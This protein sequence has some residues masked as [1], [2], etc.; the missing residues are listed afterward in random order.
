MQAVATQ[1]KH[2]EIA[3]LEE[4]LA[5]PVVALVD[6][7]GIPARQMMEM[8]K[9]LRVSGVRVRMS[10]NRLLRRA[11]DSVAAKRP[12][13]EKL[14]DA[15]RKE[16]LALLTSEG[17]PFTI[18]R[19]LSEAQTQAPAKGGETA[20][21]DIVI[22]KGPT[23]FP[24]GPIVGEFQ[25]AGFPAAIQKGQIVIRKRHVAVAEGET[26]SAPVAGALAKL[27]IFPITMGMEL[28]GAY[29]GENFYLP[30]VLDIDYDEFRGQLQSA[31]A[32][33][34]N[35]AMHARWFSDTTTVPLLS[36]A[37]RDALAVA[38]AAAWPSEATIAALLAEAHQQMLGVA[39]HA[40]DG[41]DDELKA[42]QGAAAPVAAAPSTKAKAA[43]ESED[44][45]EEEEEASEEDAVSG[46]GALFE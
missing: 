18:F 16:Q 20:S 2:D 23:P 13:L 42:M 17:S 45:D 43:S 5:A 26:I 3:Q 33:A 7:S 11:I 9:S 46:L 14:A 37:R 31:T 38:H 8:R 35:L 6:V 28:L 15:F 30:E 12:G 25:Q 4:Y 32:G 34:F 21:A 1:W 27:E 22:E 40:G 36:K 44:D 10:R 41:A 39:G 24:A 19:M 29:D